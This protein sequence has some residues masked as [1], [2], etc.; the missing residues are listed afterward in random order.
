MSV[1]YDEAKKDTKTLLISPLSY[2]EVVLP[3]I[4]EDSEVTVLIHPTISLPYARAIVAQ[5]HTK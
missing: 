3:D 2:L 1:I 4:S 5:M